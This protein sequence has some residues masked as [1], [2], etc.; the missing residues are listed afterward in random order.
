MTTQRAFLRHL[1]LVTP[2]FPPFLLGGGG[3]VCQQLVKEYHRLGWEVTVIAMGTPDAGLFAKTEPLRHRESRG[4]FLPPAGR[5][6]T[7]GFSLALVIPPS[8]PGLLRM[9][10][11]FRRVQWDAVHLHG[12]PSFLVDAVGLLC[13]LGTRPYVLTFHGTVRHRRPMGLLGR[14]FLRGIVRLERGIF[15]HVSAITAVSATTLDEVR[16]L[17][18][19]ARRMETVPN[20]GFSPD[21]SSRGHRASPEEPSLAN[22]VVG[23]DFVLCL[24]A[25]IPRKGQDLLLTAFSDVVHHHLVP[26]SL[27]LVFAGFE[28]DRGYL[29][30]LRRMAV[31][32]GLQSRIDFL[33]EVSDT[34]RTWLLQAARWVVMP[35][36]YEAAPVLVLEAMALGCVVVVPDLASFQELTGGRANA[37][38]FRA[39]DPSSLSSAMADLARDP[40]RERAI[41]NAALE[42]SASFPRWAEIARTY[43]EL[44][45]SS[46]RSNE[47]SP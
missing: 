11:E 45:P 27:R 7:S 25:F 19:Q 31:E 15:S 47:P 38:D 18:F 2:D 12:H 40:L 35:S 43:L 23:E 5:V 30:R 21:P 6:E 4:V 3:L 33:G 44:F 16:Q 34:E 9:L 1:L 32:L 10:R 46:E 41:R 14:L 29:A 22:G 13:R 42:R 20:A 37:A 26:E 8:I 17:G 36:R 39:E 28:R 24:G